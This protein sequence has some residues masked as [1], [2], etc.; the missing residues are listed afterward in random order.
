M[1]F[2]YAL[3]IV[4]QGLCV[5]HGDQ[6]RIVDTWMLDIAQETC[7]E[8]WHD[9]KVAE[10]FHKVALL[11]EE[12]E[13]SSQFDYLGQIVI[14]VLLIGR[15]YNRIDQ[16]DK[17]LISYREL[18]N[19]SVLLEQLETEVKKG[20]LAKCLTVLKDIE[21]PLLEIVHDLQNLGPLPRVHIDQLAQPLLV[22][23]NLGR[24]YLTILS[25]QLFEKIVQIALKPCSCVISLLC[26]DANPRLIFHVLLPFSVLVYRKLIQLVSFDNLR[27]EFGLLLDLIG[28][29]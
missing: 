15:I 8:G 26:R 1:I 12:V 25:V 2:E 3:V 11:N 19:Q 5:S 4:S 7:Q 16:W 10:V 18:F 28:D 29:G 9:I 14:R 24:V 22:F 20:I 13:I 17:V 21:L 27:D 6:E 23:L